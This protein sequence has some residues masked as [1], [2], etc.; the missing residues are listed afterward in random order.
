MSGNKAT[1]ATMNLLHELTVQ[2][3]VNLMKNGRPMMSKGE[4]LLDAAGEM[5]WAPPSAA[6][7]A[8]CARILKDNG[9]DTPHRVDMQTSTEEKAMASIVADLNALP[10]L[11]EE[12]WNRH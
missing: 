11:E 6:E 4:P 10:E 8:A 7:I 5:I 1:D 2:Q 12:N 9:I 3:C